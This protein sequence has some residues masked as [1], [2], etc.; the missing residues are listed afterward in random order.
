MWCCI[1]EKPVELWM[2]YR[3]TWESVSLEQVNLANIVNRV[4]PEDEKKLESI[5][6]S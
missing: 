1:P 5:S 6:E 2:Q 4:M 3:P